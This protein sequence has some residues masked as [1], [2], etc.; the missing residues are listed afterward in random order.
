[1]TTDKAPIVVLPHEGEPIPEDLAAAAILACDTM[2][3]WYERHTPW[4][5]VIAKLNAYLAVKKRME[6]EG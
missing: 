4:T 5:E 2:F 1:M 6:G 3:S